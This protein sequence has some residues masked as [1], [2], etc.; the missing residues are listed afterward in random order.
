[1]N[2]SESVQGLYETREDNL[3]IQAVIETLDKVS[4]ELWTDIRM[5]VHTHHNLRTSKLP[6][7]V[8]DAVGDVGC[9]SY[10]CLHLHI[11]SSSLL[12]KTL[13]KL[14]TLFAAY[15]GFLV[16][17]YHIE[18]HQSAIQFLIPQ[19]HRETE[20][21][22]GDIRILHTEQYLLIVTLGL[23]LFFPL[24]SLLKHYLL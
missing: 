19:Q 2:T 17:V 8:F 12:L 21:S 10:L 6:E 20:Q 14:K 11:G 13:K 24:P 7:G 9:Q 1:M 3:T 5:H 16:I 22:W 15:S 4:P 23:T 18:C